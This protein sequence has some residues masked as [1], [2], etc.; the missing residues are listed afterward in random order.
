MRGDFRSKT[1][2]GMQ[3]RRLAGRIRDEAHLNQIIHDTRAGFQSAVRAQ[4]APYLKFP[5]T[6]PDSDLSQAT[7][8]IGVKE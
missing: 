5:I 7:P 8:P 6:N 3:L 4:L 2:R 1:A